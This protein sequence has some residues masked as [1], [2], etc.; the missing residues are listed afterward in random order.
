MAPPWGREQ[1]DHVRTWQA[2][3]TQT[4]DESKKGST[5]IQHEAAAL[6]PPV[7]ISRQMISSWRLG[8]SGANVNAV[9]AIA[10]IFNR[11]P[12]E[13]LRAAGY[14]SVAEQM[15]KLVRESLLGE[16]LLQQEKRNDR[17]AV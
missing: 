14:H 13:A 1:P 16:R 10:E 11:N 8:T 9:L 4:M 12:V 3:F 6:E 7:K 2:W 5:Q 17:N 15:D